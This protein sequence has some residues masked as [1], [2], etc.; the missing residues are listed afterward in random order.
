LSKENSKQC[1]YLWHIGL[2][3][4]NYYEACTSI[5]VVSSFSSTHKNPFCLDN[6]L[7]ECILR[8]VRND[9]VQQ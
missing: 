3:A 4:F 1:L 7:A 2:S 8:T 6:I 9:I 5:V